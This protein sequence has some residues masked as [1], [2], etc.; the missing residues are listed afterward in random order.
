MVYGDVFFC[1]RRRHSLE[2]TFD[3]GGG[4]FEVFVSA[5]VHPLVGGDSQN[6]DLRKEVGLSLSVA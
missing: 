4:D 1:A 3:G 6:S 2:R 5:G